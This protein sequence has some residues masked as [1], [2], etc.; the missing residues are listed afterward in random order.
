[1]NGIEIEAR[2]GVA[3]SAESAIEII[4][5]EDAELVLVETI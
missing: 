5:L 2:D 4:A 1:V 3:V